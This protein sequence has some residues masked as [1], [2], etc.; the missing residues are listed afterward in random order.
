M[1]GKPQ[2]SSR[3]LCDHLCGHLSHSARHLR[4]RRGAYRSLVAPGELRHRLPELET[5]RKAR[6]AEPA[7]DGRDI[8]GARERAGGDDAALL[9][10]DL[11]ARAR[12]LERAGAAASAALAF[13]ALGGRRA[14]GREREEGGR[15]EREHSVNKLTVRTPFIRVARFAPSLLPLP[16]LLLLLLLFFSLS[17]LPPRTSPWPCRGGTGVSPPRQRGSS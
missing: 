1:W 3:T 8:L 11:A 2:K 14:G 5:T 16:L 4:R 15:R 7:A 12:F 6:D 9:G 13:F 17:A 10:L